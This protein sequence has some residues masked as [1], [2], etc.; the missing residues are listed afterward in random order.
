MR[1]EVKPGLVGH[2]QAYMNHG[3]SKFIRARYNALVVRSPV[4]YAHELAMLALVGFCVVARGVNHTWRAL[5]SKVTLRA[6]KAGVERARALS[7]TF[8]PDGSN[9]AVDVVSFDENAIWLDVP[10]VSR[11]EEMSGRLTI[12]LP[13]GKM[14]FAHLKLSPARRDGFGD[15]PSYAYVPASDFAF[16]IVTRYALQKVVVPHKAHLPLSSVLNAASGV[17]RVLAQRGRLPEPARQP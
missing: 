12:R 17:S 1:F 10:A 3:T 11:S 9:A 13:D 7:L 6:K 5:T 16:H 2:T 4:N 8:L 15:T 14:R